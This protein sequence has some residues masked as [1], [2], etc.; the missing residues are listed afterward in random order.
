VVELSAGEASDIDAKQVNA[1]PGGAGTVCGGATALAVARCVLVVSRGAGG[2]LV[3]VRGN[4]ATGDG[5]VDT[6]GATVDIAPVTDVVVPVTL[7]VTAR[8]AVDPVA[9]PGPARALPAAVTTNPPANTI[10]ATLR[11]VIR[12]QRTRP[13]TNATMPSTNP[14]NPTKPM[15]SPMA[16]TSPNPDTTDAT[17]PFHPHVAHTRPALHPGHLVPNR[18]T[19]QAEVFTQAP[20][21]NSPA[22]GLHLKPRDNTFYDLLTAAADNLVV[23]VGL[24]TE[25]LGAPPDQ[26]AAVADRMRAAEHDGDDATHAIIEHL[27]RSF[28]TPFDRDDIYRLAVRI[29]DV[30][31]YMEAAVDLSVLYGIDT[32]PDGVDQ[33]VE[34]LSD[35]ARLTAR[36]MPKLRDLDGLVSFWVEVNEVENAADRVYRQLLAT[37]FSGAYDPLTVMKLKEIVDQLEAAADSFE[38]VADVVH[39][40]AVKET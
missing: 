2:A 1:G 3:V 28:V 27:D 30:M 14:N 19:T 7:P 13:R 33:Q 18:T 22:M 20:R 26:R 11:F 9:P 12:A 16:R 24:L 15:N 35:A 29:D 17:A 5:T 10:A 39:S 8:P 21:G 4:T 36:A 23:G 38:H 40:I 25:L 37:L 34:L 6:T 31:D 32:F